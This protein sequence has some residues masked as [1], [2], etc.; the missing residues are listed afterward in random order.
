[1]IRER[2]VFCVGEL[3]VPTGAA[4][5]ILAVLQQHVRIRLTCELEAY[6]G[7]HLQFVTANR[8]PR[9][10][11][12]LFAHAVFYEGW[13]LWC[14]QMVVDLKIDRSPWL[15]LQQLHDALWRCHRILVDLRLQTRR[16]SY[17]QA[18]KHMEKHLGFTKARAQ[19]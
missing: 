9:K 2:G 8:H 7:H 14:E 5:D 15:Q 3:R 11:R 1:P 12:R 10:W 4:T 17:E 13:T 19:G 16:Y 18:V 6:P